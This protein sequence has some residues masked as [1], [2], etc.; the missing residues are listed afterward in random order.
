MIAMRALAKKLRVIK[1]HRNL[2]RNNVTIGTN[3][4][5]GPNSWI[6]APRKLS[7]G[8]NVAVGSNCRIEVDGVVGDHV[9]IANSSAI[10]GKRDHDFELVGVSVRQAP[11]LKTNPERYSLETKI[12]SDVWIGFGAII[13][14]GVSVGSSSVI[15]AGSVVTKDVPPNSVV[16]GSP[17]KVIRPRY[18]QDEL[19]RHWKELRNQGI[20]IW[21]LGDR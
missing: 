1:F 17:A 6:W 3:F 4:V 7:I 13:V 18:S 14:S 15:A 20:R 16:A 19:Q 12:G 8:N 9:L 2:K 5:I 10:V 11:W 21:E